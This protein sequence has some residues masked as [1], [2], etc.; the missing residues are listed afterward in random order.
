MQNI[1]CSIASNYGD[2]Q[3]IY[4]IPDAR[5]SI[6]PIR[7]PYLWTQ[8]GLA[9]Q[10]WTT[11]PDVLFIPAHTLP[12]LGNPRV[13]TVVTIHDLGVE[14]LP[15]YHQFP[16]KL[17]MT[18]ATDWAVGHAARI[19]AVSQAT[20]ADI[21]K[22]YKRRSKEIHVIYEA[23]DRSL[24][25]PIPEGEADRMLRK[26]KIRR[27][28]FLFVGTIQPR[29]NLVRLIEAF[30]IF[31]KKDP[32]N[33]T[34]LVLAG[35]SGWLYDAI[36]DA[37]QRFGIERRV[38]FIGHVP[39][40]DLPALYSAA[41]CFVF[42]SLF[43]GFGLPILEAFACGCPVITSNTSSMPEVAGDAA[44]LIDPTSVEGIAGAMQQVV[45]RT[46]RKRLFHRGKL[47]LKEFSWEKAARQTLAILEEAGR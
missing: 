47:Q 9:L 25:R 4:S 28:Y 14:W 30:S 21:I 11:S 8:G 39:P 20:Q 45:D 33:S 19:I 3:P 36:Y 31:L 44:L 37:P 35:K 23:V 43:E 17:Y 27:P 41:E 6:Q 7:W 22:R 29:K 46:V 42:P 16:Q 12:V 13:R 32:R 38:H 40:L 15:Q 34:A 5:C 2:S 18:W 10:T 24:F 26:Y 1:V